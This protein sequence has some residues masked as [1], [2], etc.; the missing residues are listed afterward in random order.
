MR[1]AVAA[2]GEWMDPGGVRRPGGEVHAWT[3]GTTRPFAGSRSVG[4]G[5]R[6]I[7]TSIGTTS[8]R[9]L[10]DTPMQYGG[11]ARAA[12][13]GPVRGETG[14]NG[15]IEA[16]RGHIAVEHGR[17]R[18]GVVAASGVRLDLDPGIYSGGLHSLHISCTQ[19]RA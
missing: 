9:S 19:R 15:V 8:G 14:H 2:S 5:W 4:L 1:C 13:P 7:P 16:L 12:R 6:D 3:S 17:C 10:A 18:R 11:C